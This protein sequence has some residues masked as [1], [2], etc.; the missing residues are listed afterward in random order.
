MIFVPDVSF[1]FFLQR[2]M[3]IVVITMYRINIV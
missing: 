2:N 3:N 1:F